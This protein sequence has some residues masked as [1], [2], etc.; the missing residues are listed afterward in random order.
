MALRESEESFGFVVDTFEPYYYKHI[1]HQKSVTVSV[2][3]H[4]P[5]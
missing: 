3:V 1:P 5:F 2:I 4:T